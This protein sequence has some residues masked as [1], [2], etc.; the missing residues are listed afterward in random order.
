LGPDDELLECAFLIP[1]VRNSDRQPH[2]PICWSAL[3]DALYLEFG[4]DTGP[5]LI[6]RAVRPTPGA[7]RDDSGTRAH[8][9]SWRYIAAVPRRRLDDLRRILGRAANT[10]DQES[11]Y[12]SV[13]GV[14]E[15]VRGTEEDGY[16]WS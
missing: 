2:Q 6:H 10:F 12:L 13:A 4:G 5:E 16:L 14:V 8:D 7:Y 15:F 1:L 3:E 9:E 11:I